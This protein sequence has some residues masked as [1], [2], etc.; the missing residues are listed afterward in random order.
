MKTVNIQLQGNNIQEYI[1]FLKVYREVVN[2]AS[3]LIFNNKPML[4]PKIVHDLCYKTLREKFS[5]FPAQVIIKA[6]METMSAYKSIKSNKQKITKAITKK[7]LS[8]QLD[9]HLYSK[10][11]QTSIRMFSPTT[12]SYRNI[13]TF[14]EYDYMKEI[15]KIGTPKSPLIFSKNNNLFLS[16]PFETIN[17]LPTNEDVLGIDLGVRRLVT[18][19]DGTA[20]SGKEFQRKL[21]KINYLK[22]CLQKKN[23]KSA[24]KHLSKLKRKH[25]NFSKNYIHNLTKQVLKTDK[26][27]I[28]LENL[29]KIKNRTKYIKDTK[30]LNK[31][32]NRKLGQIP[33]FTFKTFLTY[34][35]QIGRASCRERV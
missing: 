15:F 13:L 11:T 28:V 2:Y 16:I 14:V 19:S 25:Y 26:D 6:W 35:A 22:R 33:F 1:D 31:N 10:L 8:L 23:T 29:S 12:K 3:Q 30:I 21:R 5:Q 7:K 4:Y 9:I 32:H 27:I 34:K 24:K 18:T 20:F 17:P